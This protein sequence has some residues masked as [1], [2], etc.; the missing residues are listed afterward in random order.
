M[1][2]IA[3]LMPQD[4]I[5]TFSLLGNQENRAMVLQLQNRKMKM[6]MLA[7]DVTGLV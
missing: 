5:P 6:V 3:S 7:R 1:I 4:A 2:C